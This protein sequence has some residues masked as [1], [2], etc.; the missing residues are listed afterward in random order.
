MNARTLHGIVDQI[1]TQYEDEMNLGVT[2]FPA[3]D[4]EWQTPTYE[5]SCGV[6]E[7]PDV[8]IGS[9]SAAAIMAA[10][11]AADDLDF[12]GATPATAGVLTGVAHLEN[13]AEDALSAMILVTD[14]AANCASP[15]SWIT[16]YDTDLPLAVG[17]AWEG[18]GIPTFVVGIDIDED[19]GVVEINPREALDE[20]AQVGGVPREGEVGFPAPVRRPACVFTIP[21]DIMHRSKTERFYCSFINNTLFYI[22][23]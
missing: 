6:S 9:G 21:E 3:A 19:G 4:A 22:P 16:Q 11:P 15:N 20:V 10:L 17:D 1:T 2:L 18:A 7:S 14:G 23:G 12:G 8:A 5:S 13:Q